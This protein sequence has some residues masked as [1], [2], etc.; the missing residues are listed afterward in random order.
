MDVV[1]LGMAKADAKKKYQSN[2]SETPPANPAGKD[3]HIHI[4]A[5]GRGW[6][7]AWVQEP[8]PWVNEATSQFCMFYSGGVGTEYLGFGSCPITADPL[9]NA[10]WT[11]RANPVI[12]NNFDGW[13]GA[14]QHSGVY[15]EGSTI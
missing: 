11:W 4:K 12:G 13:A 7:G 3:S 14:A 15:V 6:E 10:N 8:Q 5:P 1:T 9:V 2:A